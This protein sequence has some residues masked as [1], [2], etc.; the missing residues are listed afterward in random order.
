MCKE[1]VIDFRTMWILMMISISQGFVYFLAQTTLYILYAVIF[2]CTW[3]TGH[4][5]GFTNKI[6]YMDYIRTLRRRKY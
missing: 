1:Y 4:E 2:F 3:L 5:P 6:P